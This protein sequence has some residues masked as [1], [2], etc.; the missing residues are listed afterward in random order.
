M[1]NIIKRK[2]GWYF[3]DET[4]SEEHGPYRTERIAIKKM[5]LYAEILSIENIRTISLRKMRQYKRIF[6]KK[7]LRIFFALYDFWIG[8]FLD[9]K[10]KKIYINL[11]P[12]IVFSWFYGEITL[13]EK[14]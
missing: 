13:K 5:S 6:K 2:D 7:R 1:K 11:L 8:V 9:K 14:V 10:K 12:C 4:Y 3:P